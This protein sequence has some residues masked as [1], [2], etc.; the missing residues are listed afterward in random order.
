MRKAQEAT[1]RENEM[2]VGPEE[3]V[4]SLAD[5]SDGLKHALHAT[6]EL[7]KGCLIE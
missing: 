1:G 4:Q 5:A 3:A 7:F 2:A 6:L